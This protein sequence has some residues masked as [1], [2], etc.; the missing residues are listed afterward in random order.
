[1]DTVV[2]SELEEEE[3][4]PE[5]ESEEEELVQEGEEEEEAE[6]EAE[7]EEEEEEDDG[8][9]VVIP[10]LLVPPA[11][12]GETRTIRV[13]TCGWTLLGQAKGYEV[14]PLTSWALRVVERGHGHS[15]L[16]MP[17]HSY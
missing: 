5:A 15:S 14:E 17:R 11:Y 1:M 4:P 2:E 12:R 7:E 13:F 16:H 10:G 9:V 3:E 8:R 6:E